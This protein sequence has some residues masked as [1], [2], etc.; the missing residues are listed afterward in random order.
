MKMTKENAETGNNTFSILN[1]HI[2]LPGAG[3]GASRKA[4]LQR[5]PW[6]QT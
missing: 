6:A 4:I 5:V 2:W 3:V 1:L